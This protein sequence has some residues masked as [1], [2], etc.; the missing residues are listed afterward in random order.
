MKDV[1]RRAL[2]RV[3]IALVLLAFLL[4]LLTASPFLYMN[5]CFKALL[6]V[7]R[8][9]FSIW[10]Q[11]TSNGNATAWQALKAGRKV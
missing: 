6:T 3:R 7:G 8:E 5:E 9:L 10:Q 11:A 1:I 2:F 4:L